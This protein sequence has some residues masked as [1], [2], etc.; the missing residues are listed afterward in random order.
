MRLRALALLVVAAACGEATGPKSTSVGPSGGTVASDDDLLSLQ[1]PAGAFSADQKLV[2]RALPAA[3]STKAPGAFTGLAYDIEPDGLA[4][5]TPGTVSI[6]AGGAKLGQVP[7]GE[8]VI[9]RPGTAPL[10]D[11]LPTTLSR[12][13]GVA[14]APIDRLGI[15]WVRAARVARISITPPTPGVIAG[16]T[17]SLT[18]TPLSADGRPLQRP[19]SWVVRSS[20]V[21][22]VDATGVVQAIQKGSTWVVAQSEAIQDSVLVQV[23]PAVARID[24][25]PPSLT[26]LTGD[27]ARL[28]AVAR[29]DQGAV[30]ADAVVTWQASDSSAASVSADGIVIAKHRGSASILAHI[31]DI[32]ATAPLSVQDVATIQQ[33][34]DS[35]GRPEPLTNLT[36]LVVVDIHIAAIASPVRAVS[37]LASC[38]GSSVAITAPA[39]DADGLTHARF[40]TDSVDASGHTLFSN[41]A[42]NL[43]VVVTT[44]QGSIRGS[45][46]LAVTLANNAGFSADYVI[47]GVNAPLGTP[48]PTSFTSSDGKVWHAGSVSLVLTAKNFDSQQAVTQVSGTFL[49][50]T[51]DAASPAGDGRFTIL[52]PNVEN[53]GRSSAGFAS[54]SGGSVPTITK[55]SFADGSAAF[56]A[57]QATPLYLDNQAPQA[58]TRFALPTNNA[59]I[60]WIAGAYQFVAPANYAGSG[61]GQGV[62]G[63]SVV[64]FSRE[65]VER[66]RHCRA[67]PRPVRRARLARCAAHQP[68]PTRCA[69]WPTRR[70]DQSVVGRTGLRDRPVGERPLHRSFVGG[71]RRRRRSADRGARRDGDA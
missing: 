30:V 33:L 31:Q 71:V 41:G 14:S 20:S 27:T 17:L 16:K 44:S 51:F 65:R 15:V 10:G 9:A 66:R 48:F 55:A 28:Q 58:P 25:V 23:S 63:T 1:I 36:G 6:R 68:V 49:G 59:A 19:V 5:S 64:A 7:F 4:L 70:G 29:D 13:G 21:A 37:V 3:E 69:F 32:A 18:A 39:P 34:S 22:T 54:P 40:R 47:S 67:A 52:F 35:G 60:G 62:G 61:D 2:V 11:E 12:A 53:D 46:P 57:V 26:M 45:P 56:T 38:H 50:K 43:S 42:C 24:I 8:V